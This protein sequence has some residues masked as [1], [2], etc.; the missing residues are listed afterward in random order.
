MDMLVHYH[1]LFDPVCNSIIQLPAEQSIEGGDILVA[2]EELILIG[3]SERSSFAG[4][5][6]AAES[7]MSG[8]LKQY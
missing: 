6:K 7:L 5:L 4:M 1:P 8:E 2:S 3:I